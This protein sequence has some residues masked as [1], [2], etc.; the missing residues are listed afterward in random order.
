MM[1][2]ITEKIS[3]TSLSYHL[4]ND[5]R[6]RLIKRIFSV[7]NSYLHELPDDNILM[8]KCTQISPVQQ[9]NLHTE[10]LDDCGLSVLTTE[11]LSSDEWIDKIVSLTSLLIEIDDKVKVKTLLT[12]W[13][14]GLRYV[15]IANNMN[16]PIDDVVEKIEWLRRDFLLAS[17]SILR[18]IYIRFDIQNDVI[19]D[20]AY[21]VENGLRSKK[22]IILMQDGLSDRSALHA[23]DKHILY[24]FLHKRKEYVY[25]LL[26]D[27]GLP[28]L[29]L[30]R[31]R[32]YLQ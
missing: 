4:G 14:R 7:R 28:N 29:P 10:I 11:K 9:V 27:E 31:V 30:M 13:M 5:N 18:Y 15:D 26:K 8:Y 25:D 32:K 3:T 19:T 2:S 6:K 24:D 16:L 1:K 23:I 21:L 12:N 22:Q 17:K 20:W